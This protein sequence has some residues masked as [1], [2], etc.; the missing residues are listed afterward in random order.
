MK[1]L[2]RLLRALLVLGLAL[3][4]AHASP[5][6]EPAAEGAGRVVVLGFDGADARTIRALVQADPERYPTF[7][8]LAAEGTFAALE[9]VA[10]PESPVSWAALNTGQNPAKTGVPGFVKRNVIPG[11]PGRVLPGLGHLGDEKKPIGELEHAPLP[12]WGAG[13]YAAAAGGAVFLVALLL[14]LVLT[15]KPVVALAVGLL[16]GGAAA[17]GGTRVRAWLP[18]TLPRT[19]NPNQARNFWDFAGDAGVPC[20]VIDPA[21]AFDMPTP[22]SVRLL[23]G[24]GVPDARGGIGDWFLYTTNPEEFGYAPKGRGGLT[25]GTVFRVDESGGAIETRVYGPRNFWLEQR[26]ERE[27]AAVKEELARPDLDFD[28]GNEL[29]REK[30]DLEAELKRV[31]DERT[32]VPMTIRREAGGARVRI[33]DEEQLVAEG[34]WSDYFDLTFTMNP[35]LAAHAITRV[36]V[37]RL[38]QPYFELFVNVLDIDPRQPPFWQPISSP[39]DYSQQLVEDCGGLYETYGWS[40]ATMPFKDG[41]VPPELL[42]EDVEFTLGWRERV[43]MSQL[44]RDDWRVLMSVF[45]T[46]DRV[47][48]MMYR[49][50]DAG[51][52]KHDAAEAAHEVTFFGE[53]IPLSDS[54]PAIY[55]QMDRVVG[56]VLDALRPDDTLIVCSDHGF[57]SFRRQVHVNN[58]LAEL[59]FL[60]TKPL[61]RKEDGETLK[62]VDWSQTQ[63]YSL[64]MGFVYLNLAGRE[65]QGIVQPGEAD[66]IL[67]RIKD[68]FLE[69]RDPADGTPVCNDVYVTKEVHQ[70]PHLDLEADLLLGFAPPY[71]VSWASTF[72]GLSVEEDELGG[73]R[74]ASICAD[75]DSLWSGD[76]ISVALP[77]VAGVF[78]S[79]RKLAAPD[80]PV[81]ALA[82]APT[83]LELV[84]VPVPPQM[85]LPALQ[86][87]R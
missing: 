45:S 20:V 40:T 11:Q 55:R 30:G 73:F 24:L 60:K 75:N 42:L 48:H 36:R 56:R 39:F 14:L 70:G 53:R 76:H 22:P 66:A 69:V 68:A 71:R 8:R 81:R 10:P 1:E 27:L 34:G 58:V 59:G 87:G 51:H 19:T 4:P 33:G 62:F 7:R 35:V 79:N 13:A 44:A 26:L 15:R 64:G 32:S 74:P 5:R 77:D 3:A 54:I 2:P 12:T 50:Y 31:K 47:Q 57:Q 18:E 86:L 67:R 29:Q 82:I 23:A 84:G 63:A 6:S 25:A 16:L 9:V 65:P 37:N 80:A 52:P 78:F 46:T 21:Q 28:S 83:V 72:G 38:E 43:T 85:D 61:G 41:L 17:W 49:H